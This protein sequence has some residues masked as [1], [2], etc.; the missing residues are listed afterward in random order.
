M[1]IGHL[2]ILFGEISIQIFLI[3]LFVLLLGYKSS[4]YILGESL[5]RYMVC[6]YFLHSVSW[7][8]ILIAFLETQKF[9]ISILFKTERNHCYS[10]VAF[11]YL[12]FSLTHL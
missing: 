10:S 12:L 5:I 7:L 6:K 9:L 1:L 3:G 8:L 4:L 11:H 2:Y